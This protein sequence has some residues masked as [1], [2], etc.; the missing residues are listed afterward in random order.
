MI[1][2]NRAAKTDPA[3]TSEL[4]VVSGSAINGWIGG[5]GFEYK[6]YEIRDAD[7]AA[8]RVAD[9]TTYSAWKT[10]LESDPSPYNLL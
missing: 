3:A 5:A 8:G 10:A 2:C 9:P 7:V 4:Q 6:K 1:K